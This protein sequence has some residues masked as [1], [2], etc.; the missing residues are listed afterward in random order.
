MDAMLF[1]LYSDLVNKY[2]LE[3]QKLR[4][5][6][7]IIALIR[8]ILFIAFITSLIVLWKYGA[9]YLSF[10][11]VLLLAFLILVK[12]SVSVN[13]RIRHLNE[14]IKINQDEISGLKGDYSVFQPGNE[15]VVPNHPYSFDLDIFGDGSVFQ[16]LNRSC[17]AGGASLLARL[18]N[19]ND[20]NSTTI[21]ER[22]EAIK[23][24]APLLGWRQN[25]NATGNI[26]LEADELDNKQWLQQ[27]KKSY[28][29]E[30]KFHDEMID[31]L[32]SPFYYVNKKL[33]KYV[34][35]I[36]PVVSVILFTL[37]LAGVVPILGFILFGIFQLFLVGLNLKRINRIHAQIGRKAQILKK[38]GS[39]LELIQQQDFKSTYLQRINS[40]SGINDKT[41]SKSLKQLQSLASALDSRLNILI[42]VVANAYLLF[43]LQLVYRIENWRQTH[44]KMLIE[45]LDLIYQFDALSSLATFAYNN[46]TYCFPKITEGEFKIEMY[47]AGHPLIQ[48]EVRISNDL[49]IEGDKQ[50]LVITGANMAGKSTFLR[51]VGVN[52]ILAMAG[53]AVCAGKFNL[54]PVKMHT[55]IRTTDSVQKSESY[56]FAELKR[57]KMIIDRMQAGEKLFIIVDEML[58]GTNSKDKHLGSQAFIEQLIRLNASGLLATHD[59]GL[60]ELAENYPENVKNYRFEVEIKDNEL[61]FDYKL[62][63]GISQNLNATFLMKK[64]GITL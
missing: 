1:N 27:N 12:Y 44:E 5:K 3:N 47:Q 60:G 59:I 62:K 23:E 49:K 13:S 17:T 34:L 20:I 18:L 26:V 7:R 35:L 25:F 52:L 48:Q 19:S 2:Q 29:G 61:I 36:L 6:G 39:L 50:L 9:L 4:Y 30:T 8:G 16:L 46:P 55:S 45:W 54:C 22:Q 37:M 28:S 57:L 32:K 33:L 11:F 63:N 38:Y 43:D 24:I 56:F 41:A 53:S 10:S 42:S 15:F 31:W 40:I 21:I 51:T 64:M 14:L 58:R